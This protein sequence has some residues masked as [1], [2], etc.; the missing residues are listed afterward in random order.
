MGRLIYFRDESS[1][2]KESQNFKIKFDIEECCLF[3]HVEN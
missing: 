1:Q 2:K 3:K